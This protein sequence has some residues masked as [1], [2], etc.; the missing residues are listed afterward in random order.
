MHEAEGGLR[1]KT[2]Y[3]VTLALV[4]FAAG[5][6]LIGAAG[7]ASMMDLSPSEMWAACQSMMGQQP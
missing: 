1:M 4:A 5:A 6:L 7:A 2:G 3:A